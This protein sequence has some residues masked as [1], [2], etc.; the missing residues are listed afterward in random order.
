MITSIHHINFLVRDL[1]A[2]VARHRRLLGSEPVFESLP[3]RG[4]ETARFKVGETWVVLV[5]PTATESAP[6]RHLAEHGEGFFLISYRTD[7]LEE[8]LDALESRGMDRPREKPRKGIANWRVVDIDESSGVLS[9][10][11]E[12][13]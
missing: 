6:A 4:V 10:I 5:Q 13:K 12:E 3:T 8:Y 7:N 1:E 2:A 9:Q 11:A